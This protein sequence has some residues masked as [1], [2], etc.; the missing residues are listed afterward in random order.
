[1]LLMGLVPAMIACT[2]WYAANVWRWI[3]FLK[4]AGAVSESVAERKAV[5]ASGEYRTVRRSVRLPMNLMA[6]C[7][8]L[9][10]LVLRWH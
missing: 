6:A 2:V 7:A 10:Y 4:Q 3:R 1:M 8:L 5:L 9:L